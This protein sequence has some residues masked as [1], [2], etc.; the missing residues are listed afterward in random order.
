MFS[1]NFAEK[2]RT[3]HIRNQKLQ[4]AIGEMIVCVD[5]MQSQLNSFLHVHVPKTNGL[6]AAESERTKV[7][8]IANATQSQLKSDRV[9]RSKMK[10]DRVLR[11][12]RKNMKK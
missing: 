8:K 5:E 7:K 10:N 1:H 6:A 4:R 9:L 3:K 2:L 12:N 11:S